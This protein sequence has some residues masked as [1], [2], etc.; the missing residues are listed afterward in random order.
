MA[1]RRMNGAAVWIFLLALCLAWWAGRQGPVAWVVER[2]VMEERQVEDAMAAGGGDAFLE[3]E[4]S[5]LWR[6]AGS[7]V[8]EEPPVERERVMVVEPGGGGTRHYVLTARPHRGAVSFLPAV[9]FAKWVTRRFVRGPR[10]AKLA[11]WGL[12]VAFFQGGSLSTLLVGATVKP[13][14][15]AERVSH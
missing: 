11:A 9:A 2:A 15:D 1:L 12:G 10:T 7:A 6:L 13:I 14:A 4:D 8:E 3:R 5:A